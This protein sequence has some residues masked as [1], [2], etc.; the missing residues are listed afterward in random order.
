MF[1]FGYE[2]HNLLGFSTR[3]D[4]LKKLVTLAALASLLNSVAPAQ[5]APGYHILKRIPVPGQGS[6]DYLTVDE[7]ARRLYASHGTQVE[8]LDL[9][10]GAIVG[11][12][13]DTLGVHGIA[14]A[15]D[16]DRGFVSDGKT[17]T[18]TIFD[19]KTLKTLASVATGKGPDAI[20]YDPASKRVF[21]FNGSSKDA[22]AIDAKTG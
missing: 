5:S 10:S 15:P 16:L 22:T 3:E 2:G 1:L 18:V 21:A 17:S 19:L 13:P 4:A 14:I 9:D 20:I 7:K 8:V 6:W 12:L 11:T